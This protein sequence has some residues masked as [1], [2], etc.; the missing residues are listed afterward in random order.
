MYPKISNIFKIKILRD[1]YSIGVKTLFCDISTR[2]IKVF[3]NFDSYKSKANPTPQ[4]LPFPQAL[5]Q[6]SSIVD[7]V[8]PV[9]NSFPRDCAAK[10]NLKCRQPH[11]K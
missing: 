3:T 8:V 4:P 11:E 1:H 7:L 6:F 5:G 2:A 10:L 9:S